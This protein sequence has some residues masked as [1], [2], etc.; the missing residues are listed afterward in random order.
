LVRGGEAGD[1]TIP[2][3]KRIMA[4]IAIFACT[5]AAWMILGTSIFLRTDNADAV[6]GGRVASAWGNAEEQRPLTVSYQR[7]ERHVAVTEE[8]GRKIEKQEIR[9]VATFVL[10]DGSQIHAD[11]H[12]DYRKKGLLWFTAYRVDFSGAYQMHNPTRENRDFAIT[13]PLPAE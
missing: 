13:L 8:N 10:I 6:L 2:M 11:F 9:D 4:I 7:Q 12:I 5:S 3:V 1:K